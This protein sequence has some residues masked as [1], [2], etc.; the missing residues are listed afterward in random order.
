MNILFIV[1][2]YPTK[3]AEWG[4]IFFHNYAK[5]LVKLGH[6]VIVLRV[7]TQN[8]WEIK[9]RKKYF[10]RDTEI[11]DDV[12]IEIFFF[13]KFPK[14]DIFSNILLYFFQKQIFKSIYKKTRPDI[15]HIHFSEFDTSYQASLWLKKYHIP[16][17]VTEHST[18]FIE[19]RLSAHSYRNIIYVLK[20]AKYITSVGKLLQSCIKQITGF[21]SEVIPNCVDTDLFFYKPLKKRDFIE[22]IT[23]AVLV[24]KKNHKMLIRSFV[25]AFNRDLKYR[26]TILG[27]G[28]ERSSLEDEI[29]QHK[30]EHLVSL[31]GKATNIEVRNALQNSDFFVLP[32]RFE[33]FGV[34]ALEAL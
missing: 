4:G 15:A 33:T 28:P 22:F 32:S 7:G 13:P 27:E 25:K 30:I 12:R 8:R 31:P 24:E 19:K 5:G 16:F 9:E 17:I 10:I 6:N 23:V 34:V 11:R 26:L 21:D 1:P 14:I 29:K 18:S 3:Y 2:F 20:N